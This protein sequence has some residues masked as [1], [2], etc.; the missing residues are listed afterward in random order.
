MYRTVSVVVCLLL[1]GILVYAVSFL[2]S[3]GAESNP[4]NNEVP[5]RYITQGWRDGVR[6]PG[7]GMIL[8]YRAFDTFGRPRC[9]LSRHC[10]VMI[11]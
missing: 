9:C 10:C 5:A 7:D 11:L 3:V 1:I 4:T 6:E 2:P 8:T